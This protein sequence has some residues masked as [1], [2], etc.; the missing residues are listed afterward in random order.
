[1]KIA[2]V[3][4]QDYTGAG[5]LHAH[6]FANQMVSLGHEV[7]FLLHGEL[8]TRQ[9]LAEMPR[10]ELRQ[11]EMV[12]GILSRELAR[13]VRSFSPQIV[14]LWTPRHIPARVGLEVFQST[15]AELCIHYEDDEEFILEKLVPRRLSADDLALYRLMSEPLASPVRLA[16]LA[17]TI[18]RDYLAANLEHPETW[19][20]IHPLVT[21]LVEKLA[22]G[23]TCISPSYLPVVA[24][25]SGKPVRILYPG[26]DASRFCP[27]PPQPG[28]VAGTESRGSNGAGL[29]WDDRLLP[30][31]PVG[32]AGAPRSVPP[33]PRGRARADRGQ[34]HRRGNPSPGCEPRAARSREVRRARAPS[35]YSSLPGARRRLRGCVRPSRFNDHRLPSKVPE[36]M[37][38]AR[39]ILITSVG[40]G[41]GSSTTSKWS[42]VERWLARRRRRARCDCWPAE[43]TGRRW[44]R[45]YAPRPWVFFDWR[46]NT[47]RLLDFYAEL[48]GSCSGA[49]WHRAFTCG[50]DAPPAGTTDPSGDVAV[51]QR[52]RV[53][54]YTES[55]I[56]RQMSG[57][58]MRYLEVANALTAVADVAL[59]QQAPWEIQP[60][61]VTTFQWLEGDEGASLAPAERADAVIVH[62]YVL[63]RLP[64]LRRAAKRLI[65]DLYCPFIFENLEIH[66]ERGVGLGDRE[67]IHRNDL[68]VLLDQLEAGHFFLC[69][70]EVQRSWILGMLTALGRLSP[71][72]CPAGSTVE[73][74]VALLPFG[75]A[76]EPAFGRTEPV[77]KGVW[78]GVEADDF[79]LLWGGGLW[80]W[81]DPVTLVE[82]MSEVRRHRRDVKL[83]FLSTRTAEPLIAMPTLRQTQER[84]RELGLAGRSVIFN[85]DFYVAAEERRA[86]FAEADLGVCSHV[87]SLESHFAF[88]TRALDY[89]HA[90]LPMLLSDGDFFADLVRREGLGRVVSPGTREAWAEAILSFASRPQEIA[91]CRER[92]AEVRERFR[93]VRVVRPLVDY[94]ELRTDYRSGLATISGEVSHRL[95]T[96]TRYASWSTSRLQKSVTASL[97]AMRLRE[98]E[99][100]R[101]V[102]RLAVL[103]P[104]VERLERKVA[105]LKRLPFAA[106]AWRWWVQRNGT[107]V[108]C[109]E[110][111]AAGVRLFCQGEGYLTPCR[112]RWSP[113]PRA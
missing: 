74:Y 49:A 98:A 51:S 92:S 28:L 113:V 70:S 78:D 105:L 45:D 99:S 96:A 52:P 80:S 97:Q 35:R 100:Q 23:A 24:E 57:V 14:H 38:M 58:G 40:V 27:Q 61:G 79:V 102:A 2:I 56:G 91:R 43:A 34:P 10:Y 101:R 30:R 94:L 47:L 66:R 53:A 31:F 95:E 81:L 85:E 11:V 84:A 16:E 55:R 5:V 75:L 77:L 17:A 41:A 87:E 110:V 104:H 13:A 25:R 1:M 63:E 90:G 88:R 82:A 4:Y 111:L 12:G 106:S 68:R 37:A 103:E 72:T 36:Y 107:P 48:P 44:A 109:A 108:G 83:V 26:V 22:A 69:C 33:A 3:P 8:E 15:A 67:S 9:L 71:L 112:W 32:S 62:G 18:D 65:V 20:W 73:D 29:F 21:P 86:Y 60:R 19:V 6:E 50:T 59:G 39:P 46:R 42:S 76:E 54:I 64:E 7:L 89:L 93:W